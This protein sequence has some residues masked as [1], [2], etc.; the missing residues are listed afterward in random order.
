[1][2]SNDQTPGAG[3]GAIKTVTDAAKSTATKAGE[4]VET[5]KVA[6]GQYVETAQTKFNEYQASNEK[7]P[8][9]KPED[10]DSETGVVGNCMKKLKASLANEIIVSD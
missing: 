7:T 10:K 1:M 9:T 3:A 5:G 2:A 8:A 4:M 6:V